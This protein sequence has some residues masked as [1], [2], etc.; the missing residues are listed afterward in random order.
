MVAVV[1]SEV[2]VVILFTAL[3]MPTPRFKAAL[4]DLSGTIHIGERA[5]E[6]AIT[7]C[8]RLQESG[9]QVLFLTNT[10]KTSCDELL[11]QLRR[12]GFSENAMPTGS[13]LTSVSATREYLVSKGGRPLCLVENVLLE[14]LEGVQFENPNCVVV[15][16]APSV[17]QY[18]NLNKAFRL[19]MKLKEDRKDTVLPLIAIHR[20]KYFRDS[21]DELS[22]GPG[23]F[24]SCLE[25]AA[26]LKATVM[27]KPSRDFFQAALTKL[28]VEGHETVMV[29]DDVIQDC[30]GA[31]DAGLAKA[32]LV[33]TGKYMEGD[34]LRIPSPDDLV[35]DSVVEA[36]NYIL[37]E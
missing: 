11:K 2:L 35:V 30:K 4:I 20:G 5:I 10:S 7:A 9:V 22:L 17:L 15:G 27:G 25:E 37:Q 12:I 34:E 28:G 13:L 24:V 21:D 18:Q 6:G 32:I 14:D 23:G 33:R 31:K 1:L 16:L 36:V 19:L 8:A 3:T 29:G 26:G